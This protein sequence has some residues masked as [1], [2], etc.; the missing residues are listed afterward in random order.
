[1]RPDFSVTQA[2]RGTLPPGVEGGL[3]QAERQGRVAADPETY[4]GK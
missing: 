1:M 4:F 3:Q 2:A